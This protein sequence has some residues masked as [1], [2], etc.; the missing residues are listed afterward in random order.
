METV[1]Y[2][3]ITFTVWDVGG[4]D[5]IRVLWRDYFPKTRGLIFVVDITDRERL[6]EVREEL[7]MMVGLS[8]FSS[9]RIFNALVAGWVY[10]AGE[11]VRSLAG[12]KAVEQ[13]PW[14]TVASLTEVENVPRCDVTVQ[15]RAE[16][17]FPLSAISFALCTIPPPLPHHSLIFGFEPQITGESRFSAAFVAAMKSGIK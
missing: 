7:N 17:M 15:I 4:Q 1:E 3:N 8:F 16:F 12:G 5:K 11:C 2:K 6:Q 9:V 13:L 14:Y 10:S